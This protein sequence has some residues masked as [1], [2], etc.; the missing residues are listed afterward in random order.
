MKSKVKT[1]NLFL[2]KGS[3]SVCLF[4]ELVLRNDFFFVVA[5]ASLAN[6]VRHH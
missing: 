6:S 3:L 4:R 5:A 1:E 2:P